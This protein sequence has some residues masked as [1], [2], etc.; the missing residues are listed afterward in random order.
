MIGYLRENILLSAVGYE[1]G[2]GSERNCPLK[3]V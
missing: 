1:I 2:K 3:N